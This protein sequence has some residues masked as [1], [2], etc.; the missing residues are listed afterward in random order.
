MIPVIC[1][2][3]FYRFPRPLRRPKGLPAK[4]ERNAKLHGVTFEK[5]KAVFETVCR[6]LRSTT[7][8]PAR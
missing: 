2:R 6:Y 7:L 4:A 1:Q 3:S 8:T 5:A